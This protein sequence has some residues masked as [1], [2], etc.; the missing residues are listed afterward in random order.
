MIDVAGVVPGVS[1]CGDDALD[2]PGVLPSDG[3]AVVEGDVEVDFRAGFFDAE[4]DAEAR[5]MIGIET[6]FKVRVLPPT[7][8]SS[9]D[10]VSA[11]EVLGIEALG[12]PLPLFCTMSET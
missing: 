8:I 12:L 10:D 6:S 3:K 2:A 1:H 9:P 11:S 5:A 4:A 7:A